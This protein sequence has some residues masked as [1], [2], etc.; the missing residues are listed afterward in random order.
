MQHNCDIRRA[1]KSERD[2]TATTVKGR[3]EKYNNLNI[4]NVMAK[5]F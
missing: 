3:R 1:I 5:T 2:L 4:M